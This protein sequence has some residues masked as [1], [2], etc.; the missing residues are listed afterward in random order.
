MYHEI[1]EKDEVIK[2]FQEYITI[3]KIPKKE[4]EWDG[5]F[6]RRNDTVKSNLPLL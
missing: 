1:K 5:I 4:Y 6:E 2:C 3:T